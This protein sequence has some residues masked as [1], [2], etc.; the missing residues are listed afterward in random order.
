M[1]RSDLYVIY[2]F[3]LIKYNY[4]M[5]LYKPNGDILEL[6]VS[7]YKELVGKQ[8]LKY[9]NAPNAWFP[10]IPTNGYMSTTTDLNTEK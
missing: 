8:P 2:K 4:N 9:I 7:E 6:T 1:D 3:L 5:K 10:N